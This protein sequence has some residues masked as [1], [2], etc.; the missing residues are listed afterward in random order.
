MSSTPNTSHAGPHTVLV[1][2][3]NKTQAF[4]RSLCEATVTLD[5]A[6]PLPNPCGSC[7]VGMWHTDTRMTEF[8][9]E[10]GAMIRV[11]LMHNRSHPGEGW[12][13][14]CGLQ[15]MQTNTML[16]EKV[17]HFACRKWRIHRENY[18]C[19]IKEIQMS[20]GVERGCCGTAD[21][22]C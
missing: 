5:T 20:G 8:S 4:T 10:D 3:S 13:V 19:Y 7:H 21:K 22:R 17:Q 15:Q 14:V 1:T 9:Q 16:E 11:R 2:H 6:L 12:Q 18:E